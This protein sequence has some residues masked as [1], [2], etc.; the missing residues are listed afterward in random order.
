MIYLSFFAYFLGTPVS[1][2]ISYFVAVYESIVS[3]ILIMKKSKKDIQFF[4]K[5]CCYYLFLVFNQKNVFCLKKS[6]TSYEIHPS[7][8]GLSPHN[9]LKF[10][11]P[12][13]FQNL[14]TSPTENREGEVS[15]LTGVNYSLTVA[16]GWYILNVSKCWSFLCFICS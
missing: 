4:L 16:I 11:T 13:F 15:T 2:N 3:N 1:R 8:L 9:F 5:T 7:I 12:H 6:S 14:L 10:L